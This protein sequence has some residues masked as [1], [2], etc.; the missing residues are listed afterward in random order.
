VSTHP[1]IARAPTASVCIRAFARPDGLR[2]AI[3]SVLAQSFRDF[4]L[5][6]SDDSGELQPVVRAFGDL[7]VRY[8]PNAHPAGPVANIRTVFGLARGR[9]LALLDDDDRWLPGFLET[10]VKRFDQDPGLGIVFTNHYFVAGG[11]R[12][13]R[14]SAMAPGRNDD[15]LREVLNS[16][17]PPS[18]AVMRRAVWEQG[19]QDFPLRDSATGDMTMWIRAAAGGWPFYYVD[20]P[21]VAYRLHADQLSWTDE[22]LPGRSIATFDRFRFDDPVC[23]RLRGA[24]LAEA[25]LWQAGI[26]LR[27]GRYRSARL[28]LGRARAAAPS[29]LGLR[30]WLA[31]TGVRGL[32]ARC[33]G[34][35]PALLAACLT[36]WRRVR[37]PVVPGGPSRDP[38][39]AQRQEFERVVR[40]VPGWLGLQEA[41]ALHEAAHRHALHD[42]SL[43][44]VEI[45]S[46]K[47]RST[48]AIASGLAQ[49]GSGL[50]HAIDPHQGTRTHALT[51]EETTY[52]ALRH[53]LRC[54]GLER[55]VRPVRATSVEAQAG[56]A[57]QSVGLLFID[58]SHEY[59]HVAQDLDAWMPRLA[60]GAVVAFHDA[61][62]SPGVRRALRARVLCDGSEF[63]RPRLVQNT[64]LVTRRHR[65]SGIRRTRWSF[66]GARF[67]IWRRRAYIEGLTALAPLQRCIPEWAVRQ[68]RRQLG[69]DNLT[70]GPAESLDHDVAAA[71]RPH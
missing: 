14:S 19:E 71:P 56:F 20:E 32:V 5:V 10:V 59:E 58:G 12:V 55:Y 63:D 29:P 70:A 42:G 33:V 43:T 24:R 52:E 4:E 41:W 18:A 26:D 23:E 50:L 36:L 30:G 9:L 35:R 68:V 46:W 47:G 54:S 27:H 25:R 1:R 37:P 28:Q 22:G 17:I 11:R 53:N 62:T 51:S 40:D 3:E 8:H 13:R 61:V 64:L 65:E 16:G 7:R 44:A 60:D 21:L 66:R 31:L 49:A 6:V 45:G 39:A 67:R 69:L 48:T 38:E 2:D 34:D 15:F 57:E